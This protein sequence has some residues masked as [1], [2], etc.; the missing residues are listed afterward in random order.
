MYVDVTST[1]IDE[2][3]E[4]LTLQNDINLKA[5]QSAPNFWCLVD[6]EKYSGECTA[7][8]KIASFFGSTY[9]C[10]SAFSNMNFITNKHRTHMTDAHLQ[11][12]LRIAVSNYP[13]DCNALVSGE[14]HAVPGLPHS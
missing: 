3:M 13:P 12:S 6:K 7:A 4:I 10:E 1:A 5:H 9:L 14:Q 11:D 8:M 2:E